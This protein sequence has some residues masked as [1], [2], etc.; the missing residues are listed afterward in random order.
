MANGVHTFQSCDGGPGH[1]SPEPNVQ[2]EGSYYEGLRALSV[3]LAYGF[4]VSDLRRTW[5]IEGGALHSL[6]WVMTLYSTQ[7]FTPMGRT[8]YGVK[9]RCAIQKLTALIVHVPAIVAKPI[10]ACTRASLV[11]RDIAARRTC[12]IVVINAAGGWFAGF[13]DR[14][15]ILHLRHT[16]GL[17]AKKLSC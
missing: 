8:R 12:R 13:V 5:R 7:A 17:L 1:S 6:W 3:A 15:K 16:N 11:L 14:M 2:F 4:P 9:I 10:T